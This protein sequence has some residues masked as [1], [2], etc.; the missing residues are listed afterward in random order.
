MLAHTCVCVYSSLITFHT[1]RNGKRLV[2]WKNIAIAGEIA[3][4]RD[5]V[6]ERGSTVSRRQQFVD[7][8]G[9]GCF[10]LFAPWKYEEHVTS[11]ALLARS[12]NLFRRFLD[13]IERAQRFL[14]APLRI[15]FFA[16]AV[17][18]RARVRRR[19]RA[20]RDD[21]VAVDF[22]P[23]FLRPRRARRSHQTLTPIRGRFQWKVIGNSRWRRQEPRRCR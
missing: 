14:L 18:S 7:C 13:V 17:V 20:L 5:C 8:A 6:T 15:S 22:N 12:A 19:H 21:L 16:V 9:K 3:G 4:N 1:R 10:R 11:G 2:C 23:A